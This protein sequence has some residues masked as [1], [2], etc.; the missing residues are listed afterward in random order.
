MT[1]GSAIPGDDDDDFLGI[2]KIVVL[3]GFRRV[4]RSSARL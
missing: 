1:I 4:R 3:A 2:G